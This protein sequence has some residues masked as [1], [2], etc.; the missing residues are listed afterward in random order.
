MR[1][2]VIINLPALILAVPNWYGGNR[3]YQNGANSLLAKRNWYGGNRAYANGMDS[4]LTKRSS[5][6]WNDEDYHDQLD[7]KK[8]NWYAGN[9][10][11]T[12]GMADLLT[13]RSPLDFYKRNWYSGN[14]AYSNGLDSLLSK[15][16]WYGGNRAYGNG[17]DS[18][19]TKR[20]WSIREPAAYNDKKRESL[21][22]S[23]FV[24]APEFT[25]GKRF[26]ISDV[27]G[28]DHENSEIEAMGPVWLANRGISEKSS[29]RSIADLNKILASHQVKMAK[30]SVKD[31]EKLNHRE[32]RGITPAPVN[33]TEEQEIAEEQIKNLKS[34]LAWMTSL[35]SRGYRFH[36][37]DKRH[38]DMKKYEIEP[39][40]FNWL[41]VK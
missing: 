20:A 2:E 9:Q 4:L 1:V 36:Q 32:K 5:Y 27:I 13:K 12:R 22:N 38:D 11:Y 25:F 35:D 19:L 28:P 8:R 17:I 14:Q 21:L 16:N 6:V 39:E 41:L 31:D 34:F 18:L 7:F 29:K 15:R 3:A 26:A 24:G 10:A 33:H 30:R 37:E 23:M 40:I